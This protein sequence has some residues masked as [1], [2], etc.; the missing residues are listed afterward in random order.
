[1]GKIT[2]KTVASG[3]TK[4]SGGKSDPPTKQTQ[5]VIHKEK[6]ESSGGKKQGAIKPQMPEGKLNC[7]K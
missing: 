2:K 3:A 4:E 5:H 1:M 7:L 6:K